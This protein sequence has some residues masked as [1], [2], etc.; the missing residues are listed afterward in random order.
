MWLSCSLSG[1]P[2]CCDQPSAWSHFAQAW[3]LAPAAA[4]PDTLIHLGINTTTFA[5]STVITSYWVAKSFIGSLLARVLLSV[6]W[7]SGHPLDY[8]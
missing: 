4:G 5:Y 7:G 3:L 2:G 6:I 8:R 1:A